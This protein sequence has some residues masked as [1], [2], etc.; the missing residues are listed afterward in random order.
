MDPTDAEIIAAVL[1]GEV[2]RYAQ[3]VDRYQ[4]AAFRL[5]L[6]LVGHYEDAK[7]ASQEAFMNAYRAL[8]RFRGGAKFSTWLYRIVV[9]ECHDLV[10]RRAR[11]P[12]ISAAVGQPDPDDP[13]TSIFVD[14]DDPTADPSAAVIN[15]ELGRRLTQA[16]GA[17]PMRQR[18]AFVL[19]HVHGLDLTD[20]ADVMK[21]HVG[22]VKSHVF[23]ATAMLRTQL[24]PWL[25][26]EVS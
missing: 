18:T 20:V 21:C 1:R 11:A 3:L 9:N 17:L 10:R 23:R 13:N 2:D 5:A 22:T 16:I 26:E 19:H 6:G 7:D 25:N 12:V 14:V 8:G 4:A 24:A 15:R